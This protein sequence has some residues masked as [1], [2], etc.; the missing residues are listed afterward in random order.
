[1]SGM[2]VFKKSLNISILQ[3][4]LFDESMTYVYQN[5]SCLNYRSS[6]LKAIE[7]KINTL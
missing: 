2:C 5:K 7:R 3:T 4:N 6:L 1:M